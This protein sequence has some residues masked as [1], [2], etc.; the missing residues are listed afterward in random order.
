MTER[1]LGRRYPSQRALP[2]F[3]FALLAAQI[4]GY[5]TGGRSDADHRRRSPQ[6]PL[7]RYG[8]PS[9]FAMLHR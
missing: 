7:T 8:H 9:S 6:R 2:D 1:R 3:M 5:F 4:G